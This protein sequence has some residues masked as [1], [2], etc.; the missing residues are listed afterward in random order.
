MASLNWTSSLD[1]TLGTGA[2]FTTSPLSLG[3]HTITA[4]VTDLD[5]NTTSPSIGITVV[6]NAGG[7]AWSRAFTKRPQAGVA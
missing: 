1:G 6:D 2:G 3:G 5:G 7:A 4:S